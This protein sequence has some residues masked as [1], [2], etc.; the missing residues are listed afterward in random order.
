VND[1]PTVRDFGGLGPLL[2]VGPSLGTG[3][4]SLWAACA[5]QLTDR[6]R[7]LGWELPGHGGAPPGRAGSLRELAFDVVD[8][9]DEFSPD[10]P[11]AY[12]GVSIGGAVGLHLLLT[13]PQ[14]VTSAVL[15][16]TVARIG[17]PEGW[18]ERAATVR[19]GGTGTLVA[20]APA[21][22]FAPGFRELHPEVAT[23]LLDDL[24]VAD[25]ESYASLAEALADHD[26]TG[27]LYRIDVPVLAV[28][29]ADDSVTGPA[30][31]R[32]I[33]AGVPDGR[34][35]VLPG[36]AHLAPAEA[37]AEVARLI[38]EHVDR[39][40][41]PDATVGQVR[42]QGM[43]T[44]REVLGDDHVDRALA[45]TSDLTAAFQDHIT[46]S[47]WGTVWQRPG[48]SRRERSIATL[49]ALVAGGHLEELGM[50]LRAALRTG[51]TRAEIA[52][53]LLHSAVYCGLPAANSAFRVAA[54]VLGD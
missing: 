37:P 3:A 45:G 4:R 10:A 53:V 9:V 26:V 11:F 20:S 17:T 52:E 14:R 2:V 22:W 23:T 25:A 42:A 50:H 39:G 6:F 48:L 49:T 27:D 46:I 21:R 41:S 12:A 31:L 15:L 51:L 43:R 24:A 7:I 16:G 28:A 54:D 36:V 8:A 5:E 18:H 33:A 32:H 30:A 19:A 47:A 1:R 38:R 34:L 40:R 13:V 35:H 44:R 29:G